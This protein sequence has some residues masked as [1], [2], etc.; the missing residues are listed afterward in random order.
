MINIFGKLLLRS[1]LY[2]FGNFHSFPNQNNLFVFWISKLD[3]AR[4]K[5]A[6]QNHFRHQIKLRVCYSLNQR[7][8]NNSIFYFQCQY[9]FNLVIFNWYNLQSRPN[10]ETQFISLLTSS[11]NLTQSTIMEVPDMFYN[12]ADYIETASGN[13]VCRKSVLCGSQN[14]MILGK[15]NV[16]WFKFGFLNDHSLYPPRLLYKKVVSFEVIWPM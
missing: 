12:Q 11:L 3:I 8:L 6:K 4:N 5:K 10:T 2:F 1:Y 16:N 9:T 14:I 7:K 15:V 13:K